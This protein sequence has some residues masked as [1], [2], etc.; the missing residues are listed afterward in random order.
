MVKLFKK[1]V[2]LGPGYKFGFLPKVVGE[3]RKEVEW[4]RPCLQTTI[5]KTVVSG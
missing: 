5:P 1:T 2:N 3:T 4:A